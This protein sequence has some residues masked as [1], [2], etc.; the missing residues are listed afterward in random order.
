MSEEEA[1]HKNI[2][3]R[4]FQVLLG[5]AVVASSSLLLAAQEC[6]VGRATGTTIDAKPLLENTYGVRWNFPTN[7]LAAMTPD[8]SGYYRVVTLRPDGSGQREIAQ[9]QPEV[10][11][12][13]QGSPYWHPSGRYL[14]FIAQK[15]AWHGPTL[16]GIPDYE[17][18]P[19]FGRH[20]DLWLIS[21]DGLHSWQL[22]NE[23]DTTDEGVLIPVFSPD[24]Q[25]VAWSARQ[26]GGNYVLKVAKFVESPE[27]HLEG[28][29]SYQPGGTGYYETGSFTSDSES[30]TYTSDQDTHSF[31]Q[32]QIYRLDLATGQST[33]LTTGN[34][35]NEHP[36]VIKRPGGDWI[37]YMTDHGAVRQ[38]G[39]LALG[40]DW[41]A[42]RADGS[43]N[44][45]LTS[46]NTDPGNPEDI[47]KL[48]VAGTVAISP[49]GGFM[50]G[51][52]QTSLARQTGMDLVVRFT[53]E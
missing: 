11:S 8:S 21:A 18:L 52:V 42:M 51:D 38:P 10:P 41:F 19:G 45:R 25:S 43:D 29:R 50:L 31:W 36:T 13:H 39:A 9:G 33:R 14:L 16:F 20:D 26:P 12:K 28:I 22:T 48:R 17:A 37:V 15:S 44:K 47:G 30:L 3:A 5:I 4:F 6:S 27:P 40:T 35:Y 23:A 32:S 24:G 53:C 46:M 2:V 34:E 1:L 49:D 7:M